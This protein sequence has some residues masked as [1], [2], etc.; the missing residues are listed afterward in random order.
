[1]ASSPLS[2]PVRHNWVS[3]RWYPEP[4]TVLA[5][6]PPWQAGPNCNGKGQMTHHYTP[7]KHVK[8]MISG[9][10]W[11]AVMRIVGEVDPRVVFFSASAEQV[12]VVVV[13]EMENKSW[14]EAHLRRHYR[15][16]PREAE[17]AALL[18][19]RL[20]NKEIAGTLGVTVHTAMRHT[21]RVIGKLN[22][23]GRQEVRS[24]LREL[25][26]TTNAQRRTLCN[27]HEESQQERGQ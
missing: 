1:L 19:D 15:L 23:S 8:S 7:S 14:R 26:E 12:V 21:E 24:L 22:V 2:H 20:S 27:L 9:E 25:V 16:T 11:E 10:T 3:G 18:G 6:P 4:K 17:V 5:E 13:T